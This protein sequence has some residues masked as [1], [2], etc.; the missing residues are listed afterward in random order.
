[1]IPVALIRHAPTGWN[2]VKRLQGRA[3][4]PLSDAG[5]GAAA[6][7]RVPAEFAEYAWYVSPLGRAAETAR[8]LG[9]ACTTEPAVIEMHW[10]AWE[11]H[12]LE[13][14]KAKFGHETVANRT[15]LGLDF[16]PHDGE[17]PREVRERVAGWFKRVAAGGVPAGAVTH[18]GVIRA[19][20]SLATGWTM[21]GPPPAEL[22]WAAVHVFS[23]DEFG[24]V[25]IDRLNIS[26]T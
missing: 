6:G 11:G 19:A 7:W 22:D 25:A 3:D 1:M 26:L 13:E 15:A 4:Q 9:L 17:S 23:V 20:L 12:T 8:L 14:L 16:R 10:G 5:R 21:I 18:Q 2:A 24:H